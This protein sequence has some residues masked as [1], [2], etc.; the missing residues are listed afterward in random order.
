M[1]CAPLLY[2]GQALSPLLLNSL[3]LLCSEFIST[4]G[5]FVVVVFP[6]FFFVRIMVFIVVTLWDYFVL[7]ISYGEKLHIF[8]WIK[9]D[10]GPSST[11][12]QQK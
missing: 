12:T 4:V 7:D 3:Q 9:L 8:W 11:P 1:F 6:S 5:F 10:C 2:M